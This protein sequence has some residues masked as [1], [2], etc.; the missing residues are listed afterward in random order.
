MSQVPDQVIDWI[1]LEETLK[2]HGRFSPETNSSLE[3][4]RNS[5]MTEADQLIAYVDILKDQN[6]RDRMLKLSQVMANYASRKG[7]HKD[8]D[9]LDFTNRTIQTMVEMQKQRA[10]KRLQPVRSVIDEI[11]TLTNEPKGDEKGLLGYSILPHERFTAGPVRCEKG[12]LLRHGGP[13]ES[14]ARPRW[15]LI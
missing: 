15:L 9:F 6:L 11:K 3:E 5:E 14:E 12:L 8:Q 13:A 4:A 1:T 7:P 10:K 2:K